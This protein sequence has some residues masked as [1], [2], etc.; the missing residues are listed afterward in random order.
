MLLLKQ[1]FIAGDYDKAQEL[2][3]IVASMLG[4]PKLNDQQKIEGNSR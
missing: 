1:D 4:K 2:L 3:N